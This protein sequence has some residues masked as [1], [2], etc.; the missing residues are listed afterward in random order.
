MAP[1]LP[2]AV[3]GSA[4]LM[5]VTIP[6]LL[7][8]IWPFEKDFLPLSSSGTRTKDGTG[9]KDGTRTKENKHWFRIVSS[10]RDIGTSMYEKLSG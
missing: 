9:T 2:D 1:L 7:G 5:I 4:G 3:L 6:A 8:T 10:L